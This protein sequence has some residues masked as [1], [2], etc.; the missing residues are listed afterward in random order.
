MCLQVTRSA[1]PQA[2]GTLGP[3]PC[4]P[5]RGA[6]CCAALRAW[7]SSRIPAV[8]SFT[9][10]VL[11]NVAIL[12]TFWDFAPRPH[13]I[14]KPCDLS[15]SPVCDVLGGREPCSLPGQLLSTMEARPPDPSA[16]A[17]GTSRFPVPLVGA[18]AAPACV[19]CGH[20]SPTSAGVLPAAGL[21]PTHGRQRSAESSALCLLWLLPRAAWPPPGHL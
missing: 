19:R 21:P 3:Q 11:D 16:A 5:C 17:L 1:L 13:D 15:R 2:G 6:S 20:L 10:L 18:G 7:R 4:S 12:G 14:W 8:M 9:W